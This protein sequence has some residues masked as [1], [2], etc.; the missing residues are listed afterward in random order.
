MVTERREAILVTLVS[1]LSY[2][3]VVLTKRLGYRN[4]VFTV[5]NCF[6]VRWMSTRGEHT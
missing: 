1:T 3:H 2:H 5:L 6:L 4:D